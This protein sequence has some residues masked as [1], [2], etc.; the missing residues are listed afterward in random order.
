MIGQLL[1]NQRDQ[2]FRD[3]YLSGLNS[4]WKAVS[5]NELSTMASNFKA[6]TRNRKLS[7]ALYK[8]QHDQIRE[9]TADGRL[10]NLVTFPIFDRA[11]L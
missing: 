7:M 10:V 2:D 1:Y 9:R 5:E 3:A 11:D 8:G 4:L 6:L